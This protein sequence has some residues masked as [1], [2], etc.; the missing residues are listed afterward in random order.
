MSGKTKAVT[1]ELV[2]QCKVELKKQGIRGENGRRLQAIISAKGFGITAVAK[3]Y[4]ISRRTL[5]RWIAAFKEKGC[6]G[7]DAAPGRGR[8]ARI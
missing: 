4:N 8:P 6:A 5:F 2:E 3:I 7:F 1:D